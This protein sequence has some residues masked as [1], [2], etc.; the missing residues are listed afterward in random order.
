M[1]LRTRLFLPLILLLALESRAQI[2]PGDRLPWPLMREMAGADAPAV[3]GRVVLVDFWASWCAPCK[4]SFPALTQLHQ[5]YAARGLLIM[6]VGVDAKAAAYAEFR[7]KMSPPFST[8]HDARQQL[9]GT[10]KVPVMPTSYLFGRDGRL[11][12][13]HRGFYGRTTE[14]ALRHEIESLLNEKQ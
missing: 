11:R 2:Q 8:L 4:A 6:A 3:E 5:D 12:T 10:F 1:R 9:A 14:S 13:V 7:Q